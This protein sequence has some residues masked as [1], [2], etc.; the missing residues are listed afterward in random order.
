MNLEPR[1]LQ[2]FKN[3]IGLLFRMLISGKRAAY[4]SL[5]REAVRR[6]SR[7][8]NWLLSGR[9]RLL[10]ETKVANPLP[11]ILIVGAPRSG[12]TLVYQTLARYLDVTYF[13]NLTSLFPNAPLA[14][15]KMFRWLPRRQS[16]D[17]HS[18]FGQ[19]AGLCGPNDGFCVWNQW[20]GNDRYVPRENLTS[21]EKR[22]MEGFFRVW[23]A[24]F[25]KPFLN[26]NNRN[27]V[28]LD[29][30]SEA[31]PQARFVVVRRN[32]LLVAQSLIKAR[33]QVQGDKSVGWGLLSHSSNLTTDP[34]SYVDDVCDQV[35]RIEAELDEQLKSIPQNRIIEVTYK[36]FC[37][38]PDSILRMIESRVSGVRLK[39]DLIQSELRP[40]AE[41][42]TITLSTLEKARL[43]SR[44]RTANGTE[45]KDGGVSLL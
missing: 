41:S 15:T 45:V 9:E 26:K 14:G 27:A 23:C 6:L 5:M 42:A 36:G 20:L 4:S 16:A 21:D 24:E 11:V 31:I 28:C 34:L 18:F 10:R 7:P 19:T 29:L 35:L 30:L 44:L 2:N 12:T 25:D 3:P 39:E 22:A 32:P 43:L 17:F 38:A 1:P 13:T 33:Q 40:F 8:L 37:E